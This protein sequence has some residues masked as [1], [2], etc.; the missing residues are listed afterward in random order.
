MN[1]S[2]MD[3]RIMTSA[4]YGD[5][6]RTCM[7]NDQQPYDYQQR[8]A[9]KGFPDLLAVPTGAGK[10]LAVVL[11]WLYRRRFH[12]DP[13]VRQA[14]P[15]WLVI[16]Q[17]MRT[18]V[19]QVRNDVDRWLTAL[20]LD[21]PSRLG[22][23]TSTGVE[24]FVFMS[25]EPT[26]KNDWRIIADRDAII[27]GT[28]DMLLSRALNRGF[29]SSR[30]LWPVEFGAL[31][32]GCQWVFDEIQLMGAAV[33]TGRQLEAFRSL[34]PSV[35]PHGSTWMSATVDA[36]SM[37]TVDN[38]TV[39]TTIELSATDRSGP[40]QRRLTAPKIVHE[41]TVSADPKQ[42]FKQLAASIAETHRPGTLTL[43]IV[44]TV[45]DAQSLHQA[46]QTLKPEAD[47]ILLH[48][49][50]RR[51]DRS[52]LVKRLTSLLDPTGPGRICISTQVVEAGMDL[53]AATLITEAA[54][55]A[56][57]VQR[58]GR[59]NRSGNTPDA[60]ALWF[61]PAKLDKPR[62]Y[63]ADDVEASMVTLRT[64]EGQPLIAD[65]LAALGP[66]PARKL[67]PVIR[68]RDLINL[69][70][71]APEIGGADIDVSP[72][73][74]DLDDDRSVHIAW[75]VLPGQLSNEKSPNQAELCPALLSKDLST[76]VDKNQVYRYDLME[77]EWVRVFGRDLRP[78]LLLLADTKAGG[79]TTIRGWDPTVATEVP[80]VT[81][82]E[83]EDDQIADTAEKFEAADDDSASFDQP[84][85]VTLSTHLLD[86]ARE[87]ISVCS[88]FGL[89]PEITAVIETA[90]RVHDIGKAHDVFQTTMRKGAVAY[91]WDEFDDNAPMAK[92]RGRHRHRQKFFRHELASAMAL[93]G[94]ARSAL[95]HL[96][97]ADRFLCVYLV[98][99]HHGRIRT[100]LRSMPTEESGFV[101]GVRDGEQLPVVRI[102]DVV[103]P[104]S[105]LTPSK[106]TGAG[107]SEDGT[108]PWHEQASA[109]LEQHG[110][111]T[112]ALFETMVR[113]SDWRASASPTDEGFPR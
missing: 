93:L 15:H 5:L 88:G 60:C 111:F 30:N 62:P 39:H 86:A 107:L 100:A 109:L 57:I 1:T 94:G 41:L 24:R 12:P 106:Y 48:S 79:Y 14:T 54:P 103:V 68:R 76:W 102:G 82:L 20:G 38:P 6:V 16:C 13:A 81:A 36:S 97:E 25:G 4:T 71:T 17:P 18:L 78:N 101:F 44:N 27:I 43:V 58:L 59:C 84:K 105:D 47:L 8:L 19:E 21:S 77:R 67:Y 74:R 9:E 3:R 51:G 96:P 70:D 95:D 110:P 80:L 23:P 92:S 108:V 65:G 11:G 55:W 31:N 35:L 90:A 46:M 28:Q 99:S 42:R 34:Y 69:F 29:G 45:N 37:V 2:S 56:S 91:K 89:D 53:D 83:D 113:F 75:R 73:V 61:S 10:T 87:S 26:S 33:P 52:R 98:A 40:L 49:R 50:F 22:E 64:Y 112:L 72:Y 104:G 7:G 63:E 32:S 66:D 85:W